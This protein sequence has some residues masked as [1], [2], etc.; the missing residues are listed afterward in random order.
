MAA[1]LKVVPLSQVLF[2]TDFPYRDSL[3]H[4]VGLK[5]SG[6]VS[7]RDIQAIVEDNAIALVPRLRAIA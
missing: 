6:V 7:D 4:V 3:E 5:A 2:G 1:L